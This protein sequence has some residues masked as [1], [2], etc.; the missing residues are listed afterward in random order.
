[1]PTYKRDATPKEL[2]DYDKEVAKQQALRKVNVGGKQQDQRTATSTD[3][4]DAPP[5]KKK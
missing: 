4:S 3:P 2:E 5:K 1:M